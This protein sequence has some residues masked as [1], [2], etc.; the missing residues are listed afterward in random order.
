M[1][2][3]IY[4]K[5]LAIIDESEIILDN[6]MNVFTGETGSGKSL[7]FQAINLVLGKR[8]SFDLIRNGENKCIIEVEFENIDIS[9]IENLIEDKDSYLI[10]KNLIFRK[11]I[12][13]NGTSRS[14]LNDTPIQLNELKLIASK[15]YDHHGQLQTTNLLEKEFQLEL[16]DELSNHE[17]ILN[18]FKTD[19]SEFKNSIEKLNN[20]LK[21]AEK[22]KKDRDYW[23]FQL[24]E[25]IKVNPKEGEFEEVEN[26]LKIIE[27]SEELFELSEQTLNELYDG[28]NNS[29]I[30]LNNAIKSLININKIDS[31]FSDIIKDLESA[32][33]SIEESFRTI[34]DYKNNIEFNPNKIEDLRNRYNELKKLSK[35]YGSIEECLKSKSELQDN[36]SIIDNFEE[37]I[38][39]LKQDIE[40]KR[41]VLSKSA[42]I[43]YNSRLN[44]AKLISTQ[45]N[46]EL[47]EIGLEQS[48]FNIKVELKSEKTSSS[49]YVEIDKNKII[50]DENGIE[51]VEFYISTNLGE[52]E[53]PLSE[54]ASGGEMSRIMLAIKSLS[55]DKSKI[56]TLLL[57]EIDTGISGRIAQKVGKYMKKIS[58]KIQI[59]TI[60]HIPQ[61]A[62]NAQNHYVIE[63]F[64]ENNRTFSKVRLLNS[65]ESLTEI[66]KLFSGEKL[67]DTS[68][69]SAKQLVEQI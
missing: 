1:L 10:N 44:N 20:T 49:Y 30:L 9:Q 36:L 40:E 8:A 50:V 11:E 48:T 45:L 3:R 56:S 66:A 2:K 67:T 5:N 60:T 19:F 37:E 6:G 62:A 38:F 32:K 65:D 26:E 18:N 53:K 13:S 46:N 57:D 24:D 39:K 59:L 7:I 69:E 54:I 34:S 61:I 55:K 47:K 28:E 58:D 41:K 52:T 42:N 33:I 25:I 64:E 23:E 29:Y 15:L 12:N 14:F 17:S 21:N 51:N 31:K 27:N 63:K 16:L 43:L 22:L 4:I 35:K 68:I